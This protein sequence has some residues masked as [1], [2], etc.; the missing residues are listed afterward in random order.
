MAGSRFLEGLSWGQGRRPDGIGIRLGTG[1]G[2]LGKRV[3]RGTSIDEYLLVPFLTGRDRHH[4]KTP[5]DC[6]RLEA[7]SCRHGQGWKRRW[8]QQQHR[9]VLNNTSDVHVEEGVHPVKGRQ[10]KL[11]DVRVRIIASSIG[12]DDVN[13]R[14]RGLARTRGHGCLETWRGNRPRGRLHSFNFTV[15]VKETTAHWCLSQ[16]RSAMATLGGLLLARSSHGIHV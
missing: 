10:K 1:V 12:D 2:R 11:G 9:L 7:R 6:A 15:V 13:Q 3:V 5:Q 14:H 8:W 4:W 16:T